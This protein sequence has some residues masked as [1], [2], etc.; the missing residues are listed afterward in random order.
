MA[1]DPAAARAALSHC[2]VP[3]DIR[4]MA[5]VMRLLAR[6][7]CYHCRDT[8]SLLGNRLGLRYCADSGACGRRMK[9]QGKK[10]VSPGQRA[11]F[12]EEASRG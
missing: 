12:W 7:R 8:S 10:P 4:L 11:L 2:P 9:A 3:L 6:G 5:L 1:S